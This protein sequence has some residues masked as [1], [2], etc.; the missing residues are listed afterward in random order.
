M[1][2]PTYVHINEKLGTEAGMTV[3]E[4][5][6][7]GMKKRGKGKK[8]RTKE[9]EWRRGINKKGERKESGTR[10]KIK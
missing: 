2:Y 1:K 4:T 8:K 9:K 7:K 6:K 10:R 3:K 5:G